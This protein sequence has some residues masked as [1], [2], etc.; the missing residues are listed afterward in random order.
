MLGSLT[1]T[2]PARAAEACVAT[3]GPV[4]ELDVEVDPPDELIATSLAAHLVAELSARSITLC[5]GSAPRPAIARISLRIEHPAHGPM[6]ATIQIADALT[7]KRVARTLD[8]TRVPRDAQPLAVA[9][10]ADELLRASWAEI[11]VVGAP[12]PKMPVPVAVA[13][14]VDASIIRPSVPAPPSRFE[15]GAVATGASYP[16]GARSGFGGALLLRYWRTGRLGVHVIA[17][18]DVGLAR[19]AM[20]GS[21]RADVVY[22]GGGLTAALLARPARFGFD[23]DVGAAALAVALSGSAANRAR[24]SGALNGSFELRAGV[25]GWSQIGGPRWTL[26]LAAIYVPVPVR[27]LDGQDRVTGI[28]GVGGE[29]SLGF[30]FPL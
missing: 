28:G 30:F 1:T 4:V 22:G 13:R 10:S 29:V 9:S 6:L 21:A 20:D 24:E 26:G 2:A 27:A 23:V 11:L 16:A 19:D 14:T 3:E 7:D 12:A 18:V 8:L 15:V 17:G 5:V 25:R